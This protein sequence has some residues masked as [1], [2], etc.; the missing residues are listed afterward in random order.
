MA[1][2]ASG[3]D[4]ANLVFWLATIGYESDLFITSMITD[5]IG[6]H[7]VLLP[8]NHK[9]YNF[10]EK[11]KAKLWK[12]GKIFLQLWMWLVD[13]IYNFECDWL[14]ELSNNKL[15]DN[16]LAKLFKPITIEEIVIF[17]INYVII[18]GRSVLNGFHGKESC[19]EKK[20]SLRFSAWLKWVIKRRCW[21]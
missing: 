13:L 9:N 8:I 4:E 2:S 7:E 18:S 16:N 10:R 20:L 19:T 21:L 12:K 15:S 14:V 11:K 17:M 1:G 6:R 5:R 3:Q